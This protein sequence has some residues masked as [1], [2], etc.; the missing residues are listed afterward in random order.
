[1]SKGMLFRVVRLT[2]S[3]G[4]V[5]VGDGQRELNSGAVGP[6]MV[7]TGDVTLLK[8]FSGK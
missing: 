4:S 3:S 6:K 2:S 7:P 8:M 5:G 1:V